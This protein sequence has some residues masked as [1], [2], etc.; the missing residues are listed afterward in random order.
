[1]CETAGA[2]F[3][4]S[5][6][7]VR[8]ED[9]WRLQARRSASVKVRLRLERA[10]RQE[11]VRIGLRVFAEGVPL[12]DALVEIEDSDGTCSVR[13]IEVVTAKYTNAQVRGKQQAGFRLY[14]VPGFRT[15][16]RRRQFGQRDR[17]DLFPLSWGSGR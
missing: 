1:M 12:P 16:S 14:A 13:A 6:W 10:R 4:G 5:V 8:C 17:E 9:C 11:A 7:K 2:G 3:G 15:E